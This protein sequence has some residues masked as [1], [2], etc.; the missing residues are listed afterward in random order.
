M[1]LSI[2]VALVPFTF[3]PNRLGYSTVFASMEA[4]VTTNQE[5]GIQ[6]KAYKAHPKEPRGLSDNFLQRSG[7]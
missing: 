1:C 5:Q 6:N 2:C 4:M 3:T 7:G